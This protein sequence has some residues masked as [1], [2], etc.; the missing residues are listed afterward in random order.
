[1]ANGGLKVY[2]TI[3]PKRQEQAETA[4]LAHE[5]GLGQPAAALVSIDPTNGHIVAMATTSKY[6]TAPGE[7]TF[8][9]AWQ[10][11]RQ[12]GSAFKVF[13][14]MTLIH[15]YDGD[16]NKTYYTSKLLP[17]GWLPGYPTYSVHTAELSYQGT[18]SIT[19]ATTVSD[20]T[21]FAQLAQDLTLP[22]VSATAHAMGITSSLT[23]Y[24]SEALGAV[25]V[26]P[27]EMADAYATIASGGIHH[28]PTAITQG[29]VPRRQ[30]REHRDLQPETGCSARA[31]PTPPHRC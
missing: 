28:P 3:D 12:T 23:N 10:G 19:K 27:L 22:K 20:N 25:S 8:D 11:H 29:R 6:G 26:S 5:G 16:P 18:I 1:M 9:Y 4:L 7:T 2:T 31:R 15:D 30:R 21:V 17:A 24:P 13:S 14:L